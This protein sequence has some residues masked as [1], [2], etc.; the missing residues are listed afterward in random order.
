MGE[1]YRNFVGLGVVH[2]GYYIVAFL[3]VAGH[4]YPVAYTAV[5]ADIV[6]VVVAIVVVG[7]SSVVEAWALVCMCNYAN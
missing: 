3:Q 1:G 6:V 7:A 4:R 2:V 5:V